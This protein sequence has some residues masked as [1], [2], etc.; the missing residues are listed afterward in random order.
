MTD[1]APKS[2]CAL[3][4]E[5]SDT[6]RGTGSDP[7]ITGRMFNAEQRI[8]RLEA[9]EQTMK[10]WDKDMRRLWIF[11]VVSMFSAI[12]ALITA[13]VQVWG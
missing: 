12:V 5:L 3:G 4:R 8:N 2:C 11:V 6:L 1:S 7:G 10:D 9:N 13:V